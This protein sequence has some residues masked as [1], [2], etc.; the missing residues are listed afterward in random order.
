MTIVF[1]AKGNRA[2]ECLTRLLEEGYG[3]V[4]V[5]TQF[6]KGHL[7]YDLLAKK[8]SKFA[9]PIIELE[10]PNTDEVKSYLEE[11][12]SDLFIL[13]GYG[14]ILKKSIIDIPRLMCIN[15]HAGKLPNY[16]GS[17][18]MNWALIN[19]EKSFSLSIIK[20]D[21]GIDTGPVLLERTFNISINDTIRDLHCIADRNFPLMLS[22]ILKKINNKTYGLMNQDHK[23][24]SY[25]PL[26]FPEDGLILWDLYTAKQIH[27]RIRALTE[28]YPCAFTY[29]KQKRVR[30]IL[31]KLSD[32]DYFGE[33]GRVYK[34]S[35][36]H[37]L[38][39]CASDKCLWI[40]EAYFD[41]GSS[42]QI[43]RY[44]CLITIKKNIE[45]CS[46]RPQEL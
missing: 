39:V 7:W 34:I 27:N 18:P 10:D 20:I 24:A 36:K 45:D 38:L 8:A 16:R 37:G 30:L 42:L 41:D 33:P 9:I 21:S 43:P 26:R 31:S 2:V 29:Y 17:S 23:H 25:Y 14:K 12:C 3:I 11:L 13:A 40:S 1:W 46:K 32:Y 5:I 6:G 22:C 28:P 35:P 44:D 19:G 15:L 4:L